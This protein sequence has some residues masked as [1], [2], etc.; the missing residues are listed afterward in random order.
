MG[1]LKKIVSLLGWGKNTALDHWGKRKPPTKNLYYEQL[2]LSSKVPQEPV[3]QQTQDDLDLDLLFNLV[4]RTTSI[5]GQQCLYERLMVPPC[6]IDEVHQLEGSIAFYD[7]HDFSRIVQTLAKVAKSLF[8]FPEPVE[9]AA[10]FRLIELRKGELNGLSDLFR[11]EEWM[12]KSKFTAV[13]GISN[14]L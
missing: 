6:T 11:S 9:N 8:G 7:K 12:E 5:I 1:K 13:S 14:K 3:D 10:I 4:D 2:L